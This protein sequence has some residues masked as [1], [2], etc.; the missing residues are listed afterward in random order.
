MYFR[1][2]GTTVFIFA[3]KIAEYSVTM[4]SVLTNHYECQKQSGT[5]S[6]L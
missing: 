5:V 1:I 2:Y 4:D 3:D 6:E